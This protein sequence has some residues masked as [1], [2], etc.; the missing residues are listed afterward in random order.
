MH[1]KKY[2]FP[3]VMLVLAIL[4]FYPGRVSASPPYQETVTPG[5]PLYCPPS[6]TGTSI[7]PTSAI[8]TLDPSTFFTSTPC[9]D[10]ACPSSTP[11]WCPAGNIFCPTTTPPSLP[12][13]SFATYTP[14]AG[15]PP[16]DVLQVTD[17]KFTTYGSGTVTLNESFSNVAMGGTGNDIFVSHRISGNTTNAGTYYAGNVTWST[18]N[19]TIKNISASIVRVY[20]VSFRSGEMSA[21][22]NLNNPRV[23]Y[24][25]ADGS[26]TNLSAET[27]NGLSS[28]QN[29]NT[30]YDFNP[31]QAI[32]FSFDTTP[33]GA[34]YPGTFSDFISYHFSVEQIYSAFT[35]TPP[36]TGTPDPYAGC[37]PDNGLVIDN[38]PIIVGDWNFKLK[39]YECYAI[40]PGME[41]T[42]PTA[43]WLP[44]ELPP[45]IGIP[46]VQ[47]C[48]S[49]YDFT[50]T[51]FNLDLG[52]L[53]GTFCAIIGAGIVANEIR[54]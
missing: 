26:Q 18:G 16:P 21:A 7:I 48:I 38:N 50:M 13:I 32:E 27:I 23:L 19:I 1:V 37:I 9:P 41:V 3:V 53:L 34:R 42:I 29:R 25:D 5:T 11:G 22:S 14:T 2:I 36:P 15:T 43:N 47:F 40:V 4:S 20:F 8:A 45:T 12:T 24:I 44:F 28:V 6:P 17:L 54:S 51:V 39:K 49:F 33:Q 31:N 52:Y 30:Y 46:G 10:G 35:P